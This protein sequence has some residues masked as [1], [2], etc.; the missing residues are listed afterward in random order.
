MKPF[1]D[2]EEENEI[3]DYNYEEEESVEK[4]VFE[5]KYE[6]LFPTT[7]IVNERVVSVDSSGK[8]FFCINPLNK[9]IIN[10]IDLDQLMVED[11]E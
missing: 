7:K 6:E 11:E 5:D 10:N 1:I 3:V 9:A 4:D 8:A 2:D